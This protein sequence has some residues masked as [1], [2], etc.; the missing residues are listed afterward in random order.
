MGRLQGKVALIT[1]GARG[2]GQAIAR[3][4]AAEGAKVVIADLQGDEA[5]ALAAEIVAQGGAADSAQ[6]DVS[7]DAACDALAAGFA[8]LHGPLSILVNS[9]GMISQGRIHEDGAAERFRRTL[10]VNV[11]GVFNLCR[12]FY[13]QLLE[14]RGAVVNLASIRSFVAAGNA[15]AYATSK[16]AVLQL[17]RSLAVEWAAE[18]IRVNAIAPGFVETTLVPQEEKTPQREAMIMARTPMKRQGQPDEVAGAAVYLASDEA[19]F[20]TGATIAVDG[21]YLAG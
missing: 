21:G 7:D 13:P 17:T 16:G 20:T 19:S 12:A 15:A 8:A 4:Y 9:A 14:T 2:I 5:R 6:L 18:G 11:G 1:G 10:A 3:A